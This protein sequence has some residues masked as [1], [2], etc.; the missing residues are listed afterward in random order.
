MDEYIIKAVLAGNV[1]PVDGYEQ[2][3]GLYIIDHS[4][5]KRSLTS[6]IY[7]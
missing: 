7:L 1:D 6:N 3:A 5:R 2:P 4:N